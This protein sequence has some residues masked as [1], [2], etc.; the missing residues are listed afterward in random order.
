MATVQIR[1]LDDA[2]YVI[3][4]RRAVESGRSLQEYLRIELERSARK[5]TVADA[6]ALARD[7]LAGE[8]GEV[9]MDDIVAQQ[10]EVRGE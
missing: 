8:S 1:N 4:R 6:V 9:P 2:A 10:R 3:L 5:P 7:E